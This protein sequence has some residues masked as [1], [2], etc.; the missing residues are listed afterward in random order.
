[1]Q[2]QAG[3]ECAHCRAKGLE[4]KRRCRW[5]PAA[6]ETPP[7]VV[8]AKK[9]LSTLVCPKSLISAESMTWLEE[10]CVWK[11]LGGPEINN[12]N[13][14]TAHAFLILEQELAEIHARE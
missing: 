1:M 9:N 5:I 13:A 14:R 6:A 8:W 4:I 10:F 3:W 2:N 12:L 7:R 11:K